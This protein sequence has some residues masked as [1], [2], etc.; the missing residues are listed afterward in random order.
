MKIRTWSKG[1]LWT[2]YSLI[3]AGIEFGCLRAER[4]G[5]I[6]VRGTA[7]PDRVL[8]SPGF[9]RTFWPCKKCGLKRYN[10][11]LGPTDNNN[12][13][14]WIHTTQ[15]SKNILGF[16]PHSQNSQLPSRMQDKQIAYFVFQPDPILY[17]YGSKGKEF[18]LS[19]QPFPVFVWYK[20]V[21]SKPI[22]RRPK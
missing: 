19:I 21:S 3:W 20:E 6:N 4:S 14:K 12:D 15:P 13:H 18:V 1:V 10:I 2:N 5:E 11:S 9:L 22:L 7:V 17:R 16:T 8:I